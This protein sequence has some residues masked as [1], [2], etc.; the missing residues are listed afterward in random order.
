MS[1]K[2]QLTL[3]SSRQRGALNYLQPAQSFKKFRVQPLGCWLA[4]GKLKL[5]DRFG[6]NR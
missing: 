6:C 4:S 5:L 3:E 2:T 1:L